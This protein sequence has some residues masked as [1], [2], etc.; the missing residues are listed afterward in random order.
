MSCPDPHAE[1]DESMARHDL[2]AYIHAYGRDLDLLFCKLPATQPKSSWN[3]LHSGHGVHLDPERI[4]AHLANV[5]AGLENLPLHLRIDDGTYQPPYRN[6]AF[7]AEANWHRNALG[8]IAARL[9]TEP[10]T[11]GG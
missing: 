3:E 9:S 2:R 5:I 1:S 10:R 8:A 6:V 4:V 7:R 11:P